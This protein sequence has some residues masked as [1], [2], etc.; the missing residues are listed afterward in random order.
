MFKQYMGVAPSER[1]TQAKSEDSPT[2]QL[3]IPPD[4]VHPRPDEDTAKIL[5]TPPPL[6]RT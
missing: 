6:V 5:R 4:L 2:V 1:R 3:Q